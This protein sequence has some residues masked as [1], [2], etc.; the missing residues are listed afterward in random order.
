[1]KR[2]ITW[3]EGGPK[4]AWQFWDPRSGPL[5]GIVGG[6]VLFL[7]WALVHFVRECLQ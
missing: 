6:L 3:L 7:S 2:L 4:P 5:G 1:M